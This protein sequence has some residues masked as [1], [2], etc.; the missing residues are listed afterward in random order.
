MNVLE[1]YIKYKKQ[2]IILVSGFS[3]S[4]KTLLAKNIERD[5]KVK[6]INL[7]N[8]YKEDYNVTMEMKTE[9]GSVNVVDW[10]NPDAIDWDKFNKDVEELIEKKEGVVISGFGFY[11]DKIK[12]KPDMHI[13]IK[14][15]KDKLLENRH[16]FLEENEGHK[17]NEL[18]DTK[19]ELQILNRMSYPHYIKSIAGTGNGK[20]HKFINASEM[21]NDKIYDSSFEY[22]IDRIEKFLYT[23]KMEKRADQSGDTVSDSFDNRSRMAPGKFGRRDRNYRKYGDKHRNRAY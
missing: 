8:Y 14:I 23:D 18:K 10:D 19:L 6:Y 3:G 15:S 12:F 9:E 4:G 11:D 5:F 20:I 2:F 17:L 16:K 13:H 7:N 1:A 21:D 22:I